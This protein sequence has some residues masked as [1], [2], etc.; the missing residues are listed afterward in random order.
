MR[1]NRRGSGQSIITGIIAMV[2]FY[3]FVLAIMRRGIT[4]ADIFIGIGIVVVI[5]YL[6][7]DGTY[8]RGHLD[9]F[10][11]NRSRDTR[12]RNASSLGKNKIVPFRR[13]YGAPVS[14]PA[15]ISPTFIDSMEGHSFENYCCEILRENG[16]TNAKVTPGSGDYGVDIIAWYSGE[17]YAIQVKR[18]KGNVGVA[19]VQQVYSGAAAYNAKYAAVMTNSYFTPQAEKMARQLGVKLWGRDEL[20]SMIHRARG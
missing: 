2:V 4:Y 19:A 9:D 16:F 15:A 5:I 3:R 10:Q 13:G 11:G 6:N 12:W 20:F 8:Y 14:D 18:Y 1:G 17:K 7:Q